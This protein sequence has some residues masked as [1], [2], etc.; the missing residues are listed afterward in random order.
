MANPGL[1]SISKIGIFIGEI[2]TSVVA[3]ILLNKMTQFDANGRI[4]AQKKEFGAI[5]GYYS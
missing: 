4:L 1:H 3:P 5:G 2:H